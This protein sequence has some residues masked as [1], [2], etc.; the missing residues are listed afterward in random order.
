MHFDVVSIFPDLIA[1]AVQYGILRRAIE[2]NLVKVAVHDLR[3]YCHDRHCQVDDTPYGGGAGMVM[4]PEPFFEA[5]AGLQADGGDCPHIVLLSPQGELLTQPKAHELGERSRI[6]LLCARYEGVDE[7]VRE[8]LAD[9]ELS[10][11]D[12]VLSGGEFAAL[13][14]MDTVSRLIEGVLGNEESVGDESHSQ[15]LLEYPQYTRPPLYQGLA[16]PE[17]LVRGDHEEIRRWRRAE[18]LRRTLQR[19]PDLLSSAELT[20]EDWQIL[21]EL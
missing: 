14:V 2:K 5:V 7:R 21:G 15:G 12:Y 18:A 16:V 6:A 20:D 17:I 1:N 11:G 8:A 13:V 9:E 3:D 19:R 10:I 4:K